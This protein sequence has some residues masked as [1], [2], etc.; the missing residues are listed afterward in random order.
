MV[1]MYKLTRPSPLSAPRKY[2]LSHIERNTGDRNGTQFRFQ[3]FSQGKTSKNKPT[4]REKTAKHI[5][6]IR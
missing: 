2:A 6:R 4:S 1:P 3:E 5:P